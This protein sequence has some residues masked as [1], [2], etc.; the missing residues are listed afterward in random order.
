MS[1]KEQRLLARSKKLIKKGEINKARDIYSSIL[2]S[3]PNN[4]EAKIGLLSLNQNLPKKPS[5]KEIEDIMK[6]YASGLIEESLAAINLLVL[7]YPDEPLLLNICGV[8]YSEVGLIE[9]A[10]ENFKKA[11]LLKPD[12]AEAYYNLGVAHQKNGQINESL[13]LYLKA[14]E[15]KHVYPQ[16]H[17]NVGLIN[18]NF[19]KLELA[20]SSFEWAL[21]YNPNY[22]E[23]HNNLGATYQEQML[24][25]KAMNQY[26][27]AVN[28]NSNY[29]VALNNLGISSEIMGFQENA[30][31]NY[32]KA[33]S[34]DPSYSEAHR[35]LSA[36]KKYTEKDAQV[37]QMEKLYLSSNLS[38]LDKINLSFALAK[39]N[40]D[41]KNYDEVFK[42]LNEGNKLRKE[43]LNYSFKSSKKLQDKLINISK[44]SP[45][46][47][48]LSISKNVIKK[49]PIFIV[50][51]PRSGSTLV[52][53]II[54]NHH[55]VYGA[56]ELNNFKKITNPLLE[57]I[58]DG[59]ST[60]LSNNDLLIIRNNY[61]SSLKHI[62]FKEAVFTDK[63]PLNFEYIG[64]IIKAFPEAK[65]I[66]L[67]RDARAVCW[68]IY[69][70]YFSTKGNSWGYDMN[71]LVS[72]YSI[73]T[74]T[75]KKW[76]KLFPGK[77]F[78]I[79]YEKLT[80]NQK[81][82]TE[83]LLKFC[84]LDWDENCLNFH[85]NTR[86][87]KTASHSQVRR[88]MYQG[89]SE[90]WKQYKSYLK[91]IIEGLKPYK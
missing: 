39:V 3:N 66:H 38:N 1:L 8:C 82:E 50:G 31:L 51:M 71:D 58:L 29:V 11:I 12:Y 61:I 14:I 72:F 88:E 30:M 34:I 86:A 46:I 15:L 33:I 53:Q 13:D 60:S 26:E 73:Y 79:G 80:T 84:E 43:E 20:V 75:M 59:N 69:K 76:H 35:N 7:E 19:G 63:M 56:G 67:K 41:L 42:Y 78:D 45:A 18:M 77:I 91:P 65:I 37:Q 90:V 10:K 25:E 55:E 49:R 32:V 57:N 5:K 83:K 64:F 40:E 16:A 68:S 85:N 54:S 6:L 36:I 70:N 62:G 4:F 21:A 27:K 47:L 74:E 24:Y 23:A 87:V 48:D 81:M 89:S 17:N 28:I 22:A 52:E 9:L 2:S 44:L